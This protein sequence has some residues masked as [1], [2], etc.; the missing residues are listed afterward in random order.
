MKNSNAMTSAFRNLKSVFKFLGIFTIV[1][2]SIYVLILIIAVPAMLF[3][4]H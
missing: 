2:L 3:L 4:N 1:I